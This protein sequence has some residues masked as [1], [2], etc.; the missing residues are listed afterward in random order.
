[1]FRNLDVTP[2]QPV[3]TWG[4]EGILAALERGDLTHWQRILSAVRADPTGDVV[5]DLE[6]AI[7][8][9]EGCG[10]SQYCA[11]VL[12]DILRGPVAK[13]AR[14]MRH[15]VR[16]TGLTLREFANLLG[17][18]HSRLSTYLTGQVTPSAAIA[19]T[20]ADLGKRHRQHLP[21]LAR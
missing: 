4:V 3:S 20:S 14:K 2:E 6:Q 13:V 19:V 10:G 9:A 5:A 15:D 16:R 7:E 12:N 18:S 1:M 17:T 8:L 21:G 11:L